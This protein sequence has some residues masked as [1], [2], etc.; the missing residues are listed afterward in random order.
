MKRMARNNELT[1]VLK[2]KA[3]R[4]FKEFMRKKYPYEKPLRRIKK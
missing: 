1:E 2:I 3:L 4:E